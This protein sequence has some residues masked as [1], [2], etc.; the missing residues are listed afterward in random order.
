MWFAQQQIFSS[1]PHIEWPGATP[2]ND[3]LR[4]FDWIRQNTPLGATF[5]IDP[6]YMLDDDEHGFRAIAER[7][8]LADA[9][10]DAGAVT[11]FP[12]PPFAE[13]WLEQVTDQSG[14]ATFQAS[15]FQRLQKKYGV[16]WIVL[17]RPGIAEFACPYQNDTILV[18]RLN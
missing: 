15:D 11:M 8:R 13:H 12:Q 2:D 10:K 14:W 9:V 17:R 1:S 18:C 6:N 3:W 7:S 5:A 16:T 4:S